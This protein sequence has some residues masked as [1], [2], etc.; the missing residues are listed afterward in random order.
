MSSNPINIKKVAEM[1][2]VS[3]ASV[4]RTINGKDGVGKATRQKVLDTCKKLNYNPS[5]TARKLSSGKEVS[6]AILLSKNDTQLSPYVTLMYGYLLEEL[7]KRGLAPEIVDH[8]EVDTISE[9]ASSCLVIAATEGDRRITSLREQNIP[10][11]NIGKKIDGWWVAPDEF[12][13]IRQITLDLINKGRRRVAFVVAEDSSDIEDN[14]RYLGYVS[15]L[16]TAGLPREAVIFEGRH[17]QSMHACSHFF[18]NPELLEKYDGFVCNSDEIAL[19]ILDAIQHQDRKVPQDIAV[20]GFDD[21]PVVSSNLTTVR[22]D[23][24]H[25]AEK[26]AESLELAK[27]GVDPFGVV[28]PV[29]VI[30]R[31]TA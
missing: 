22:Q 21:L 28:S 11:V 19:G 12:T 14:V 20:T 27:K 5:L 26:A 25:I 6:V 3:V 30:S 9:R 31:Q 2:G 29:V 18:R 16:E 17:F 1:A 8:E 10:F 7:Q 15:A 4:S 24:L 23:L 13:G